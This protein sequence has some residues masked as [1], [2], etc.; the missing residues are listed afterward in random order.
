MDKKRLVITI[1][2]PYIF[3]EYCESLLNDLEHDFAIL[4]LVNNWKVP[5]S[6]RILLD[7]FSSRGNIQHRFVPIS[8][9]RLG[10]MRNPFKV[11]QID[12]NQSYDLQLAD[13]FS[14]SWSKWA[15]ANLLI[16]GA[17]KISF[18]GAATMLAGLNASKEE[19]FFAYQSLNEKIRHFL[20]LVRTRGVTSAGVIMTKS[21]LTVSQSKINGIFRKPV[22]EFL[23]LTCSSYHWTEHSFDGY[24]EALFT[25]PEEALLFK[26]IN[27]GIN[28]NVV[29]MPGFQSVEFCPTSNDAQNNRLLLLMSFDDL[30]DLGEYNS[31]RY[32]KYISTFCQEMKIG[33]ISVRTH[34]GIGSLNKKQ[35]IRIL[36]KTGIPFSFISSDLPLRDFISQHVGAIGSPSSSLGFL[37]DIGKGGYVYCIDDETF[38]S[39]PRVARLADVLFRKDRIGLVTKDGELIRPSENS[40]FQSSFPRLSEHLVA[41]V[42]SNMFLQ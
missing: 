40:S 30:V 36:N 16:P 11:L 29:L 20:F 38:A 35:L 24:D 17:K 6:L 18:Y 15:S 33:Q 39:H 21:I 12:E 14:F 4:I 34:I 26:S 2:N 19:T 32:A 13:F 23:D 25:Q 9:S 22:F 3:R 5:D 31:I 1:R 37:R 10:R 41:I 42:N 8:R 27:H 7:K 28:A